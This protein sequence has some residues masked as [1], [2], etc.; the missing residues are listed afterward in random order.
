MYEPSSH[1]LQPLCIRERILT[2]V[3]NKITDGRDL[4]AAIA[5]LRSTPPLR[6]PGAL[7][8][9]WNTA[10]SRSGRKYRSIMRNWPSSSGRYSRNIKPD[11]DGADLTQA[12]AAARR[13]RERRPAGYSISGAILHIWGTKE[14]PTL[15]GRANNI[16]PR[17]RGGDL[18]VDGR[19]RIPRRAAV[20]LSGHRPEPSKKRFTRKLR[21]FPNKT[22]T[23]IQHYDASFR[24]TLRREIQPALT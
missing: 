3:D 14:R 16:R 2:R 6:V 20:G 24:Y 8:F 22:T 4:G 1:Y 9:Y 17:T 18:G 5:A 10:T 15:S 13:P 12:Y 7:T 23:P 19:T 11:E 21:K